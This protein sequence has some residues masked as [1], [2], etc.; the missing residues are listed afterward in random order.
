MQ[1]SDADPVVPLKCLGEVFRVLTGKAA[2]QPT[3]VR[4]TV[5]GCCSQKI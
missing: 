3:G 5:L 1:L 4:G 2:A